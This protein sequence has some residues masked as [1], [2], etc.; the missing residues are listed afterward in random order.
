MKNVL[1]IPNVT[2]DFDLSVTYMVA[3]KLVSL[4]FNVF[5]EEK[6]ETD[7]N[8]L[9]NVVKFLPRDLDFIAVIG[10]DGSVIDA[11]LISIEYGSWYF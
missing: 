11:S 3:K 7:I 4:D 9:V 6:Y 10:G 8:G 5:I 2:K 1:I